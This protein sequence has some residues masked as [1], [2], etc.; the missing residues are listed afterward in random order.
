MV[1][2]IK[3]TLIVRKYSEKGMEKLSRVIY[4]HDHSGFHDT[5]IASRLKAGIP[6]V[7]FELK[8]SEH[9][10][11]VKALSKRFAMDDEELS[12]ENHTYLIQSHDCDIYW[13]FSLDVE[14]YKAERLKREA[15]KVI[16]SNEALAGMAESVFSPG[17]ELLQKIYTVTGDLGF[18][19]S[20][21]NLVWAERSVS[22]SFGQHMSA[23]Y[24]Q[25]S[26]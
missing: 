26:I 6:Q 2:Q 8:S 17:S 13:L 10:N 18:N 11:I 1:N 24:L 21:N 23:E 14:V 20:K 5:F 15:E 16:A 4:D 9:A 22:A 19:K 25:Q 7:V 12:S 3:P